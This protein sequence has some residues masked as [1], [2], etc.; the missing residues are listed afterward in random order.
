MSMTATLVPLGGAAAVFGTVDAAGRV[1][2]WAIP[3]DRQTRVARATSVAGKKTLT[4]STPCLVFWSGG[5]CGSPLRERRA[6]MKSFSLGDTGN[7]QEAVFCR[8]LA[9]A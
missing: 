3:V 4:L 9:A 5:T 2:S 1:P 7:P 6:V 8:E